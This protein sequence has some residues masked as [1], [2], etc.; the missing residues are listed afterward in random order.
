[1][2]HPTKDGSFPFPNHG[3]KE[4]GKGLAIKILK[5]AGLK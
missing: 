2:I 5:Q 3:T 1:M 4:M